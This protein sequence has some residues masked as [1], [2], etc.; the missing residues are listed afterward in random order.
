MKES[1]F[2]IHYNDGPHE[3]DLAKGLCER[4]TNTTLLNIGIMN[5]IKKNNSYFISDKVDP[6]K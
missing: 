6:K 3:Q 4:V 5:L 2:N 1:L